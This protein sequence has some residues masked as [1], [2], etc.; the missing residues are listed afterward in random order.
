MTNKL[1]YNSL[2]ENS[3]RLLMNFSDWISMNKTKMPKQNV[4]EVGPRNIS[5]YI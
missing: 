5:D 2:N 3:L 1:L 4:T